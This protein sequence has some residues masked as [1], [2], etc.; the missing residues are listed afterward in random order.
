LIQIIC[1]DYTSP[2][3]NIGNS[4]SATPTTLSDPDFVNDVK[5]GT[6]STNPT[7]IATVTHEYE[8]AA[9]LAQ[10][11]SADYNSITPSNQAAMDKQ[12]GDLQFALLAIFDPSLIPRNIS[13]RWGGFDSNADNLY[14]EALSQS[15]TTADFAGVEFWTP[16][17]GS[18]IQEY[19][20]ITPEPASILL[21][22]TGLLAIGFAVRKKQ[23]A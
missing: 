11:I 8:A 19:I 22:G 2:A 20:T 15:Y 18:N 17:P 14:K 12:I 3:P 13:S 23:L 9:W 5:F 1:D 10:Q 16:T 21:F 6:T 7:T 4:W